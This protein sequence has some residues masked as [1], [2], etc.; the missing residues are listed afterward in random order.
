MVPLHELLR[1]VGCHSSRR[2]ESLSGRK[3]V[4]ILGD[5]RFAAAAWLIHHYAFKV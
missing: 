3:F 4:M 2:L 1:H 5:F